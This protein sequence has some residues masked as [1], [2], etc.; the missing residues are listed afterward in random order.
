MRALSEIERHA[1]DDLVE[2]TEIT[3]A[4]TF[5]TETTSADET[6]LH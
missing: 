3:A 6:L 2:G 5:V 4:T 1:R